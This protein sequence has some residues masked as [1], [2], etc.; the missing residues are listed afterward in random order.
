MSNESLYTRHAPSFSSKIFSYA[1]D[2]FKAF[3]EFNK[4]ALADG[5]ISVK[6]KEF[7]AVAVAHVT[8]CPYCI[9]A[10]V[11][12]AKALNASFEELFEAA[13]VGAAVNAHS[14]FYQSVN[15]LNAFNDS[16]ETDLYS[17]SNI[18][19]VEQLEDVNE[20][21]YNAFFE[22][23]HKS[24]KPQHIEAKEKLLIA[25]GSAHVTG[26]AYSIEIFTRQAKE[27]GATLEELAETIVVA[28]VLK[29]GSAMAHRV[30]ALQAYERE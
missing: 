20:G 14:A 10:H 25:V 23:L 3:G 9:E 11:G 8:G 26:S 17:R 18:E 28:T 6:V 4:E 30:N 19:L 7:I 15:A 21:L 1:P 27:A 5:V 12:K 16:K 24:L 29:A 22:Y 13:A 2:A